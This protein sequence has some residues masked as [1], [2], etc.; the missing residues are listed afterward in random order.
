VSAHREAWLAQIRSNIDAFG[1]H[2]TRVTGGMVP[3]FAYTIGLSKTFGYEAV[4]AG[5]SLLSAEDVKRSLDATAKSLIDGSL[6]VDRARELDDAGTAVPNVVHD[7]WA[8]Q[9]LLG[10]FDVLDDES[11]QAIQ[12]RPDVDSWSIDVPDLSQ[13]YDAAREPVWRWLAEPW[14]FDI[15]PQSVAMTDPDAL[16]GQPI[17]EAARWEEAYWEVF[18]GAGPDVASESARAVPLAT[19]LGFD[20]SLAPVADLAVGTSIYRIAPGPWQAWGNSEA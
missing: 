7:S 16:R 6:N 12:V 11:I 17:S 3:R 10:A 18:A 9:L 4:L 19:L 13:P 1:Y 15:S 20:D 2:V 8:R 14:P 5:A